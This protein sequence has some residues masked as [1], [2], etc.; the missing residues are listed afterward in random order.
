M[1][2]LSALDNTVV[3][4]GIVREEDIDLVTSIL[5]DDPPDHVKNLEREL[6][7][8]YAKMDLL[9][10]QTEDVRLAAIATEKLLFEACCTEKVRRTTP[11]LHISVVDES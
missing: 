6:T 11:N 3:F 8:A 5:Y 10:K 7:S 1:K 4:E 9:R 2:R